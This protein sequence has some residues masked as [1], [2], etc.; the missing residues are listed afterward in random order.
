MTEN[1]RTVVC[2]DTMRLRALRLVLRQLPE[3][4]Q[5]AILEGLSRVGRHRLG[6]LDG[7]IVTLEQ[8]RLTA[9]TWAQP[10]AGETAALWL[11]QHSAGGVGHGCIEDLL[12]EV[13]I[14]EALLS[15]VSEVCDGVGVDVLQAMLSEHELGWA[16]VLEAHGFR[17]VATLRY[18]SWDVPAGRPAKDTLRGANAPGVEFR[19]IAPSS[20][21]LGELIQESYTASL[22]CPAMEG[23]RPMEAVIEG[24]RCSGEYAPELWSEILV[25]GQPAGVLLLA[26]HPT[27]NQVELIYMGISPAARGQG[28]GRVAVARAQQ[29]TLQR[30]RERVV[31][32]VDAANGPASRVYVSAGFVEWD[33]RLALL[34]P[35]RI[36][37]ASGGFDQSR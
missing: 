30:G 19:R 36:L 10:Q 20:K 5:A 9:A 33:R 28:L 4:S 26:D 11:P 32:A 25:N 6:P 23:M 22:D 35:K 8:G 29:Q 21:R 1:M 31:L 37:Y 15:Q 24:Y 27:T 7:L 34:R 3:A 14:N 12:A 16:P 18:M 2:P 13:P 17:P